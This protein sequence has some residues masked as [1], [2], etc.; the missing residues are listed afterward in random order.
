MENEDDNYLTTNEETNEHICEHFC[1]MFNE[2][3]SIIIAALASGEDGLVS[4]A[5]H[6][7]IKEADMIEIL[8]FTLNDMKEKRKNV[9]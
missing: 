3:G 7:Y 9:N 4:I 1:D 5:W 6:P 8:E 2:D